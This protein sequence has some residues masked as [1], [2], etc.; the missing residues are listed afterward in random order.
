MVLSNSFGIEQLVVPIGIE[1]FKAGFED[2][3]VA[4]I[5]CSCWFI[6]RQP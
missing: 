5:K 4:Y 6:M 1:I 3:L 2:K